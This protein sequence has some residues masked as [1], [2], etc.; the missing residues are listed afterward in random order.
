[1]GVDYYA[2]AILGVEVPVDKLYETQVR[3]HLEHGVPADAN[4]CPECGKPSRVERKVLIWGDYKIGSFDIIFSTEADRA[5][6]GLHPSIRRPIGFE[7]VRY[8]AL[9]DEL[10]TAL[11]PYGLW[12][13]EK[14][15]LYS[16]LVV[17]Y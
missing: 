6:V 3:E 9:V 10:R 11:Q 16:V 1:M 13:G 17:S 14:F 5:F 2:Y 12:D 7:P 8:K 4:F 15:G